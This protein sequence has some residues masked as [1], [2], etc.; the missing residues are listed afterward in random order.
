MEHFWTE[1]VALLSG[2]VG[3]FSGGVLVQVL[4]WWREPT[5]KQ[6]DAIQQ[7]LQETQD[8]LDREREKSD[9]RAREYNKRLEAK[10][11]HLEAKLDESGE[12]YT[13]LLA[14]NLRLKA[15]QNP[16]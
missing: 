6:R 5:D 3:L 16:P 14:E 13:A 1:I 2:I 12:E 9:R 10:I 8:Q 15:G 4:R 11:E 7:A